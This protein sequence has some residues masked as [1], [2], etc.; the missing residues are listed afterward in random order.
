MLN[1]LL[2]GP[3]M[4][5]WKPDIVHETYYLR[6]ASGVRGAPLVLTVYDMIHE[7]FSSGDP[8]SA[9]KRQAVARADHII[10]ISRSTQR[11]LVSLFGVDERK[12]SV[13]LLGVDPPLPGDGNGVRSERPFL[14]FV[15]GRAGY[16]NFEGFLK[17]VAASSLL[18]REMD[19]V[20]FGGGA[21]TPGEMQAIDALGFSG[22]VTYASGDDR[23]LGDYYRRAAA[24]VYP[25]LYEGFGLP[26]LEA[27]S[28][29]CAVLCSN[30]SSLPEVVGDAAELFD[31]KDEM[32][33]AN[34]IEKV[35]ASPSR[36]DELLEKGRERV[37]EF[38]WRKCARETLAVYKSVGIK[39]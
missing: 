25:S 5:W 28:Y 4:R 15:G 1:R 23:L 35:V 7:L 10:C 24:L 31:P 29:D 16:K 13:T 30:T 9:M 37:R 27:M 38:T 26:P 14:L 32:A 6:A 33:I 19:I 22:Q 12:T 3:S 2:D 20:A 17:A 36:R 11:D 39:R 34:A 18:R 8:T 21:F